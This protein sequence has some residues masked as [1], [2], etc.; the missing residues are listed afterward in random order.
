MHELPLIFCN[1]GWMRDYA[2]LAGR[3]D[4]IVGGGKWVVENQTGG[5]CC[6]FLEAGGKVYGH[7]ETVHGDRDRK[8]SLGVL[9]PNAGDSVR[10]HVV[11]TATHPE[12][13]GRRIVG[14]YRNATVYRERQQFGRA[15]SRQ[16]N[17]DRLGSYRIEASAADACLLAPGD[18]T[19]KLGRGKGW[20]GHVPWWFPRNDAGL[21]IRKFVND[22]R[23][24]ISGSDVLVSVAEQQD[25]GRTRSPAPAA[26]GYTRYLVKHELPVSPRHHDLQGRFA[27]YLGTT[28]AA[29]IRE[30]VQSVDLVYSRDGQEVLVEVKPCEQANV[31]FAVRTAMGQLLDYAQRWRGTVDKLVVVEQRPS[32]EDQEL[33]LVNGFGIGYPE[34]DSFQIEWP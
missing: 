5:E 12:E 11:W 33:A 21:P 30:N 27:E 2:G 32:P 6:N 3:P 20:M 34:G 26:T 19:T 17:A 7:V 8:I 31:R 22:V 16:H 24:L 14:W 4:K 15:P 1:I 10:A 23:E 18:R 28:D 13:G 29:E 9:D 25:V